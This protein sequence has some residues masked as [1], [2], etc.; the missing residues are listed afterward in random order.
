M[1]KFEERGVC[2]LCVIDERTVACV[3]EKP[4]SD[5][6]IHI[7]ILKTDAEM[8]TLSSAL[9]VQDTGLVSD[10]S[11]V[12]TS[13]GTACFLLCFQSNRLLQCIEMV[14]GRVRWQV[15]EQQMGKLFRPWSICTD[16]S[17]FFVADC[18][19][20]RLH[21]L[22]VEEGSVLTSINLSPFGFR[23]PGCVLAQAEHLYIGHKKEK[24][25]AYCISKFTKPTEF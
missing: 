2:H 7:Y 21:L 25:D 20:N 23:F 17:A 24:T 22:S 18:V 6:L 10:I 13:D 19:L 14:G 3:A 8:W 5:G 15:D 11:Y 4:S 12:K 1:Y 9:F 16:G